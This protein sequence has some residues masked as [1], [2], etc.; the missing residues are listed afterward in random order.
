MLQGQNNLHATEVK[1]RGTAP[2]GAPVPDGCSRYWVGAV[3]L[4]STI[5]GGGEDVRDKG[6]G[7]WPSCSRDNVK[8]KGR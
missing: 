8:S 5:G 1:T 6:G 4:G 7:G 3:L 2:C